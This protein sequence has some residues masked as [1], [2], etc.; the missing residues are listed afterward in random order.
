MKANPG[1]CDQLLSSKS[2]EVVSIDRRQ[3]T[4][5]F[6]ETIL[7]ITIDSELNFENRRSALC[8]KVSRKMNALGRIINYM[9]LEKRS[10]VMKTFIE[11]QF[12]YCQ[13]IW[14]FHSRTINN[15]IN[16][17]HERALRIVCSD[18]KS[19]FEVLLIKD[20]PF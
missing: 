10:I 20:N 3:T 12:N 14:M 6:A 19:S 18:F 11:S 8:N 9:P 7:G 16:H 13:L 2:P 4:S 5:S 15:K 17:L 1:K